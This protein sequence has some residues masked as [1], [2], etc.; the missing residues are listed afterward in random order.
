MRGNVIAV[1]VLNGPH[2]EH[3]L[4]FLSPI[5][6]LN[7]NRQFPGDPNGTLNQRTAYVVF[8]EVVSRCDALADLHGGDIG[9]DLDS[10]MIYGSGGGEE[11]EKMSLDMARCFDAEYVSKLPETV[12]GLSMTVQAK[13]RIPCVTSEAGAPYPLRERH[14]MFHYDGVMNILKYFKVIPGEPVIVDP[15]K[16]PMGYRYKFEHGGGYGAGSTRAGHKSRR[17][18]R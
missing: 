2:F 10:M 1:T 17:E 7:Q 18:R 14:I 5:D 16:N 13:Y 3:K 4:A 11:V 8:N 12:S 6:W 9:E 15:V